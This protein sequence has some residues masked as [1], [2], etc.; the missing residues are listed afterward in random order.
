MKVLHST[1]QQIWK[2]QQWPEDWER[3]VSFQVQRRA[4][5]NNVETTIQLCSFPYQQGNAQNPSSQ[6]STVCK[7]RTSRCTAGFRKGRGTK[8]QITNIHWIIKKSK[9]FQKYIYFCFIDYTEAFDCVDQN[10]LWKKIFL[11]NLFILIGG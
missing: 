6:A 11:I 3:S 7:P 5:A 10:K 2:T 4:M 8:D 1:C 9:E